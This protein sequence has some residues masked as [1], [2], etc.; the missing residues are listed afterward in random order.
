M[1]CYNIFLHGFFFLFMIFFSNWSL[2]ILFFSYWASWEFSFVVF[3][4]NNIVDCY[5]VSSHGFYF[6]ALFPY[7]FFLNYLCWIY[8]FIII[9]LIENWALAFPICF[10]F[11]FFFLIFLQNFLLFFVF[12]VFFK[13]IFVNFIFYYWASWEFSFLV[14]FL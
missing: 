12:F 10:F 11:V 5:S 13:I 14:F 1:D 4:K 7:S 6:A 2:S 3:L 8:F 9:E